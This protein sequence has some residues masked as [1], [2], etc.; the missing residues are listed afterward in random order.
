MFKLKKIS[1]EKTIKDE[2]NAIVTKLCDDYTDNEISEI[3]NSIKDRAI[4]YL[5]YREEHLTNQL[6]ACKQS[7]KNIES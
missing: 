5:K 6:N 1:R 2:I 3:V 4:A 7:I